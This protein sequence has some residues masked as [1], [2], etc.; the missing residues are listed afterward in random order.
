V[1]TIFVPEMN[2]GM[3]IHPIREALRDKAKRFVPIPSLG[4]LHSPDLI[5]SRIYEELG[6]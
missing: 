5:L 6:E 1:D 3:M 2:L 4:V